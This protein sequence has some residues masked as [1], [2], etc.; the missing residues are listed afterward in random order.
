MSSRRPHNHGPPPTKRGDQQQSNSD[1]DWRASINSRPN[2]CGQK[3]RFCHGGNRWCCLL[4]RSPVLR[5]LGDPQRLPSEVRHRMLCWHATSRR[6]RTALDPLAV[7]EWLLRQTRLAQTIGEFIG[8]YGVSER[9]S[10]D[11]IQV[12]VSRI[13]L[14]EFAPDLPG[15]V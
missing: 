6:H 1:P 8:V 12:R 3:P 13:D 4:P 14:L 5:H 9:Q 7:R 2:P 10:T 11:V 15:L